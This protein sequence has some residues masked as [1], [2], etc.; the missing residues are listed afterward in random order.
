MEFLIA[1]TSEE[2][3]TLLAEDPARKILAG[4]TDFMVEVNFRHRDPTAV[5]AIDR[6]PELRQWR[7]DGDSVLIGSC[8]TYREIERGPLSTLVPA[9]AQSARTIGSPQIRNAGTIG[10]NLGTASPAGDMIPVLLALNATVTIRSISGSRTVSIDNL[11]TGVKKTSLAENEFIESVKV[12]ILR[13]SQEFLKVGPRNAMVISIASLAM[14]TDMDRKT[15]AVAL[16]SVTA[17][18]CRATEAEKYIENFVDWET[19]TVDPAAISTF[20]ELVS[21][22]SS[23]ITDHRSSANYRRHTVSVLGERALLRIFEERSSD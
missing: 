2:V 8:V 17:A 3:C 16:G 19:M 15:I 13:G 11:I 21:N 12:P 10:G 1:T 20:R 22:A 5:I 6:V 18:P 23:P 9:L 7:H 14:V 4:G